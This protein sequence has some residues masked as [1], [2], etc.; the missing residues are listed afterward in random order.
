MQAVIMD[1]A[2]VGE[3]SIVAGMA[4]VRAD[5]EVPPRTLVGGIPAKVLR[6]LDDRDVEWKSRG[7]REYQALARR[8]LETLV[9]AE[10]LAEVE[11]DR[12]TVYDGR[13]ET[14]HSAR[15]K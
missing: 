11:N 14:L 13:F 15:D 10:P 3:E 9:P 4:F 5:F 8:S 7:T 2:V 1:H 12:P 6:E